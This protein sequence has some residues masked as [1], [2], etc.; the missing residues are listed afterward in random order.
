VLLCPWRRLPRDKLVQILLLSV[1]LGSLHFSLMFSG[2]QRVDASLASL[3]MPI[4]VPI[5]AVLAAIVFRDR[6]TP[7]LLAG[8]A[9]AF[10]GIYV[11]VGAPRAG[12]DPGAIALI[13]GAA[14][15]WAVANIQFKFI[16]TV[17][18]FALSGWIGFFAAPQLLLVSLFLEQDQLAVLGAAGWRGFGAVAYNAVVV[19]IVSYALWYPLMRRYPVSLMMSFTLLM[20]LI[21]VLASMLVLGETVSARV[22]LGGLATLAGVGVIILRREPAPA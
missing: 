18:P 11:I 21:A 10:A 1:S 13:I 22:A 15:V 12:N 19:T 8:M 4:Q 14:F 20:P 9:I 2:L 16:G 7:R 5:G 6:L 17:D 3:L